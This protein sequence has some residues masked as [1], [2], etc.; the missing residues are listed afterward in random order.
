M[1]SIAIDPETHNRLHESF[2]AKGEDSRR[3]LT[4]SELYQKRITL[5]CVG[6]VGSCGPTFL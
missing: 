3:V 2:L 5:M 6:V 1:L 4:L